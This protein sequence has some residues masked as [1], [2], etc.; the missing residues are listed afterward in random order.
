MP[1]YLK[2]IVFDDID[3]NVRNV[4]TMCGERWIGRRDNVATKILLKRAKARYRYWNKKCEERAE[5][6]RPWHY[7]TWQ[8]TESIEHDR[9]CALKIIQSLNESIELYTDYI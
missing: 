8:H 1:H 5:L 6:P 4:G 9:R 3:G 7:N 2:R